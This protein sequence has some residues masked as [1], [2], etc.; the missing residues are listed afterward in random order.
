MKFRNGFVSNSSSSSF[1]IYGTYVDR[2]EFEKAVKAAG[3]KEYSG[4]PSETCLPGLNAW[5]PDGD[6]VYLGLSWDSIGDDQTGAQ[7]KKGVE[8][9][10]RKILPNAK[11]DTHEHA[12]Y[13]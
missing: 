3:I 7:F 1:L 6:Y 13:S 11:I 2:T 5:D 12:W 9:A 4:Y 8:E 10:I